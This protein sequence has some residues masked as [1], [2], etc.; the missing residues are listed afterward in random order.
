[1]SSLVG[2][3]RAHRRTGAERAQHHPPPRPSASGAAAPEAGAPAGLRELLD[4][5]VCLLRYLAERGVPH[6][7]LEAVLAP[8]G[9][10]WSWTTG[11]AV[12]PGGWALALDALGGAI[13]VTPARRSEGG[14][15]MLWRR[16]PAGWRGTDGRTVGVQELA[17]HLRCL[18]PHRAWVVQRAPAAHPLL[19]GAGEDP[20]LRIRTRVERSGGLHVAAAALV[21]GRRAADVL[22]LDTAR[23]V[24]MAPPDRHLPLAPSAALAAALLR[25]LRVPLW[26]EVV[27]LSIRA[28]EA[29]A[30]LGGVWLGV[31]VEPG[32]PV[33]RDVWGDPPRTRTLRGPAA[34]PR[35]RPLADFGELRR[36][37]RDVYGAATLPVLARAA[38]LRHRRGLPLRESLRRGLLEPGRR[39][40]PDVVPQ[41]ARIR[42]QAQLNAAGGHALADDRAL[43]ALLG[44]A[45]ALPVPPLRALLPPGGWGWCCRQDAPVHPDGWEQ[46]LAALPGD[47]IVRPHAGVRGAVAARRAGGAWWP[48][49]DAAALV[50]RLAADRTVPLWVVQAL[51]APHPVLAA[52]TDGGLCSLHVITLMRS[53]GRVELLRAWLGSAGDVTGLVA[54]VDPRDGRVAAARRAGRGG[55]G[56]RPADPDV[57]GLRELR[58]RCLPGWAGVEEVAARTARALLP[59]RTL[60]LTLAL[61]SAGPVLLEA[62][63][64]WE[65]VAGEDLRPALARMEAA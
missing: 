30:P 10:G 49:G 26:D 24:P 28:T 56:L 36:A 54:E 19:A 42:L 48:D 65:P 52:A 50:A 51:P 64:F 23:G 31:S 7:P 61:T 18:A 46:A 63:P 40:D 32:G 3:D 8:D 47:L 17:H 9:S 21:V 11:R 6:L 59:L 13:S 27:A 35:P 22:R 38:R 37:A 29:L 12:T 60:G 33:V 58:G 5:R 57:A 62:D 15:R 14:A 44:E 45:A 25:T 2:R 53:R 55:Y 34:S 39:L 4:D 41:A 16:V 1:M 43:L 20:H